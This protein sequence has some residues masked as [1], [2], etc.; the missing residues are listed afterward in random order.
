MRHGRYE[1][2]DPSVEDFARPLNEGGRRDGELIGRFLGDQG[3]PPALI[4]CS[5]ARRAHE[6]LDAVRRGLDADIPTNIEEVLF[7]AEAETLLWRLTRVDLGI[8]S[9]MI[10]GHNPGL[11]HLALGLAGRGDGEARQRLAG[12][13]PTAALARFSADIDRWQDLRPGRARLE[14]F[15]RAGDLKVG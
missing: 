7:M 9:V 12:G 3:I 2:S 11:Q 15:V 14:Q 1:L 10:I 6:T 4:L 5:A 13:Y 8:P